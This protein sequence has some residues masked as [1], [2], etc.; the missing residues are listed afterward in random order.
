M[1]NHSPEQRHLNMSRVKRKNTK[2]EIV[3]RKYLFQK[4]FRFRIDYQKLP[5]H[6]DIV[7]PKYRTCIF[8][9]GCFWHGHENCKYFYIPETNK[10]FWIG[11]I[12]GNIS[13][14]HSVYQQLKELGWKVVVIWECQI[15][16]HEMAKVELDQICRLLLEK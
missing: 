9:N 15:R 16:T 12:N 1:D 14:D 13:R 3:V 10:D 4:G 6:P 2:P 8:V 5:G 7:L 11:K